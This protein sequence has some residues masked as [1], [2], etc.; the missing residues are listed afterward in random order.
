MPKTSVVT[1]RLEPAELAE[2]DR[3]AEHFDRSRAWIVG[4]AI[5]RFVKEELELAAF[6]QEGEDSIDR[7]EYYTQEEMEA[8]WEARKQSRKAA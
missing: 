4:K 5:A 2:L 3:L 7:G 1:A 6:I 8:W